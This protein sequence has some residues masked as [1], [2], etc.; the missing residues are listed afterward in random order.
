ME[1]SDNLDRAGDPAV[2]GDLRLPVRLWRPDRS[3]QVESASA[4][5]QTLVDPAQPTHQISRNLHDHEPAELI[6]ATAPASLD[7]RHQTDEKIRSQVHLLATDRLSQ[8]T[9]LQPVAQNRSG[10]VGC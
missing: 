9:H 2:N 5:N 6:G 4:T 1:R 7:G 8:H 3:V 10:G